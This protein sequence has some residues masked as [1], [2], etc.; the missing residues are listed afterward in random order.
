M[1]KF[2][3]EFLIVLILKGISNLGD[4]EF[5]EFLACALELFAEGF[6]SDVAADLLRG[7][8]GELGRVQIGLIGDELQD[9]V[10][11]IAGILSLVLPKH[12]PGFVDQASPPGGEPMLLV[13]AGDLLDGGRGI[14]GASL[15]TE[16]VDDGVADG[17]AKVIAES[18]AGHLALREAFSEDS[19]EKIL[20]DVVRVLLIAELSVD[21]LADGRRVAKDELGRVLDHLPVCGDVLQEGPLGVVFGIHLG[22]SFWRGEKN[23]LKASRDL[24]T[25]CGSG[26]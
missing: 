2:V 23:G 20:G 11:D 24:E 25:A 10:I 8:L 19:G 16:V 21:V 14:G 15:L 6:G 9:R 22:S 7:E 18:A 5:S 12:T 4:D 26:R 17:S 1:A 3:F 13:G